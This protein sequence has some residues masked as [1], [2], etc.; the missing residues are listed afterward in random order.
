MEDGRPR[1]SRPSKSSTA[2]KGRD[3]TSRPFSF[4]R[5]T[6]G[7][8][9]PPPSRAQLG[10]ARPPVMSVSSIHGQ[11]RNRIPKADRKLPGL[12]RRIRATAVCFARP[13]C[14]EGLLT[15]LRLGRPIFRGFR[16]RSRARGHGYSPR[17][18]SA[19][20]C[21]RENPS[22]VEPVKRPTSVGARAYILHRFNTAHI[23]PSPNPAISGSRSRYHP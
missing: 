20:S 8:P 23:F 16:K 11:E 13:F 9:S 19:N 1:P 3:K 18:H 21:G 6:Q 15:R 14:V 5:L 7:Q 12:D 17:S 2:L 22:G 4:P 10:N